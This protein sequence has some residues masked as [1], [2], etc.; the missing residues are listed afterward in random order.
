[1]SPLN[2]APRWCAPFLALLV[3]GT[4]AL[5]AQA[6]TQCHDAG[7][8]I[9]W[10]ADRTEGTLTVFIEGDGSAYDFGGA[11]SDDPTPRRNT[12]PNLMQAPQW[13][14]AAYLGRPCQHRVSDPACATRAIWSSQQ[15]TASALSL[16][17]R[18]LDELK[19]CSGASNLELIGYSGGGVVAV[20]LA[21]M[22]A[23]VSGLVTLAAPLD[24]DAWIFHHRLSALSTPRDTLEI[25]RTLTIPQLHVFATRDSIV[26]ET[27]Y[28]NLAAACTGSGCRVLNVPGNHH[29]CWRRRWNEVSSA[30]LQLRD[31]TTETRLSPSARP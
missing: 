19:S 6:A 9:T 20:Q 22:R 17:D 8:P 16:L 28:R 27:A 12:V 24:L 25:V 3:V 23:D 13:G 14:P 11:P 31:T 26:P 1:M 2:A 5:P 29:C 7:G 21:A 4:L 18:A 15:F 30:Y 10:R